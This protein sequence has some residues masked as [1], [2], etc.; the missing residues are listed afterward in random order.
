MT[1][2]LWVVAIFGLLEIPTAFYFLMKGTIPPRT[3]TTV[4]QNL[5][6]MGGLGLW[7]FFLLARGA[8]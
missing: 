6:F 2:F 3:V 4:T 5:V 1:L 7:A 8:A